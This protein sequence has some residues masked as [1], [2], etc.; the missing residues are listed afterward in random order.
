MIGAEIQAN[1]FV[2]S[3]HAALVRHNH[4]HGSYFISSATNMYLNP[5]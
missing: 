4:I 2:M 1:N 3:R 5:C